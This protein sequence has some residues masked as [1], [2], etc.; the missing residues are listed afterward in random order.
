MTYHLI[1]RLNNKSW[2]CVSYKKFLLSETNN[3]IIGQFISTNWYKEKIKLG[4]SYEFA[5]I[6]LNENENFTNIIS[7]INELES[8]TIGICSYSNVV[9]YKKYSEHELEKLCNKTQNKIYVEENI[10]NNNRFGMTFTNEK[11][12]NKKN[13]QIDRNQYFMTCPS[14]VLHL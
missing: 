2:N 8:N 13:Q 5:V 9:V 1:R 4:Y 12:L 7:R 6:S 14:F 10:N 11:E 3:T